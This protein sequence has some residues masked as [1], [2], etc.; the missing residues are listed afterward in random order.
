MR[1]LNGIVEEV[2]IRSSDSFFSVEFLVVDMKITEEH[3]DE[4]NL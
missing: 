3:C 2:I 4:T 1:K